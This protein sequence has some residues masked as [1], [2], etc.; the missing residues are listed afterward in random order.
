MTPEKTKDDPNYGKPGKHSWKIEGRT[1]ARTLRRMQHLASS[2]AQKRA[3]DDRAEALSEFL[4]P[5]ARAQL[6]RVWQSEKTQRPEFRGQ[7]AEPGRAERRASLK[8]YA[9]EQLVPFRMVWASYQYEKQ[10]AL[11][12]S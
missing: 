11:T 12:S 4:T 6:L 9:R 3:A 2:Y 7:A 8:A 5:K 10:K 1:S